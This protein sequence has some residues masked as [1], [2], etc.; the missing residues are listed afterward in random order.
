LR[1]RDRHHHRTPLFII[2]CGDAA[3]DFSRGAVI[4]SHKARDELFAQTVFWLVTGN[5]K[6]PED[7]PEVESDKEK[8]G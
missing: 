3:V 8:A 6:E 1:L 4:R 5:K 7:R 2:S